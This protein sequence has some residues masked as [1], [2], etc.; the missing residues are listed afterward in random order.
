[1]VTLYS[2][3]NILESDLARVTKILIFVDPVFSLWA[4]CLPEKILCARG[5]YLRVTNG[6][7]SK[8]KNKAPSSRGMVTEIMVNLLHS[9][10][11]AGL[12]QVTRCGNF[13]L[14]AS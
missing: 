8:S 5:M 2:G 11:M 10:V 12:P 14:V 4:F 1:M 13:L 6:K 7:N 3:T 9:A